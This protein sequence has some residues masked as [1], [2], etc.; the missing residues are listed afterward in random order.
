ML[1]CIKEKLSLV[2]ETKLDLRWNDE[3]ETYSLQTQ[4]SIQ[5]TEE[6]QDII[7]AYA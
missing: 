6:L 7:A 4:Q 3:F 1:D 5:I 2:H